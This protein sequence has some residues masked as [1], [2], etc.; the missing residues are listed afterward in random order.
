MRVATWNVNSIRARLPRL[1]AWL[2]AQEP[3][4]VCLQETKCVDD[5]FPWDALSELGYEAVH[6]G[7]KTYNGVAILS[8]TPIEDAFRGF[9]DDAE[10]EQRRVIGGTIGGIQFLDLYVVNGEKVGSEK[11]ERKLIWLERLVDFLASYYDLGTPLVVLGDFNITRDDRD[12]YDPERFR[13]KILCSG[14]ERE[15]LDAILDLGFVDL[16]REHYPQGGLYTWFDFRTRGFE[17]GQG[18]RIDHVLATPPA[19][20]ACVEV[21]VDLTERGQEKPSD[22]APVIVTFE[23]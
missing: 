19:A 9:P 2:E 18:L 15:F 6:H 11:Y 14:P 3:D 20:R 21:E 10:D 7:Q 16:V 13:D 4:V 12:V 23:V 1:I 5:E 22:H 17:R 8:K